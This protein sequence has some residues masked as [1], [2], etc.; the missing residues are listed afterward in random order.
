MNG[1]RQSID[2][3]KKTEMLELSDA[4]FKAVV[5][6]MLQWIVMNTFNK[7]KPEILSKEIQSLSKEIEDIN[8]N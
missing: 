7:W 5:T 2:D 4:D 6:K 8:K 1:K 3:N